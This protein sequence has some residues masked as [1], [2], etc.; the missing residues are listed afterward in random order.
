MTRMNIEGVVLFSVTPVAADGSIDYT[1]WKK[2]LDDALTAG[3]HSVTLFGSTGA[4]GYFTEAE[5]MKAL[6]EVA[7]HLGGRVP[8]MTGIGAMTTAESVRLAKHA[9][10]HGADAVL[11]V[12]LNY[13]KPTERE[14]ITHYETV[15]AASDLPL[16]LYNNPPLAGIDLTPALVK[17]L[18]SIPTLVGMKDS[19]GDLSRAFMVPKITGGKVQVGIGQDTLILEPALAIVPAWFTGLANICPAEC[20]A[21]WNAA[22][23]GDVAAAYAT[24]ARLFPLSEIGGRYGI[25]RVAHEGLALMGKSAGYPRPPLLPLEAAAAAEVKA[26]LD[27]LAA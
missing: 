25:I 19:S 14:I 20:V 10:D 2:H 12:P 26:A 21:F 22:K 15:A 7:T 23:A 8:V 17:T 6:E 1:R 11:V 3:I 13:W 16:W 27:A 4:N 5:K 9:A 18:S 24:A